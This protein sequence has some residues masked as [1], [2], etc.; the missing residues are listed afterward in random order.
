MIR[1][2]SLRVSLIHERFTELGGS[3]K[4]VDSLAAIWP[5]A[6]L[7]SPLI[8]HSVPSEALRTLGGQ[9]SSLL[10]LLYGGNGRYAHL[11]PLLPAAM[12][13]AHLPTSDVVVISHH[14]F[15]N[16]VRVAPGV[17]VVSYVHT[18]ARWLWD[19]KMRAMDGSSAPHRALLTAFA[20]TQRRRDR[21][22]AQRPDVL[23]ANS[24]AVARRIER[25]WG[26]NSI[27]VHPPVAVDRFRLDSH[28][29]REPFF[30]LAGRLVPYKRPDIAIRAARKAGVPL[31]V[32]GDGR[33]RAKCEELAGPNVTFL[34]AVSDEKLEELYRRCRALVFTGVEDF[35]IVPVEAQACGAPVVGLDQGGLRDTV[36][37][38][39]TGVLVP[40]SED[41]ARLVDGFATAMAGI[42][43]SDFDPETIRAHAETFSEQR[44]QGAM[45]SI[46]ERAATVDPDQRAASGR[47][48]NGPAGPR[49]SVADLRSYRRSGPTIL[50]DVADGS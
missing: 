32:A 2:L 8:D 20:A 10:Q 21:Q 9:E 12:A 14:A 22:A 25:W 4:V 30:L 40:P 24:S 36:L 47:G 41:E 13:R 31:V 3:E 38:G 18:P 45:K 35:G 16:R 34:G 48:G 6:H 50:S 46:V 28:V 33:A 27:V 49:G 29:T 7:F 23:V 15:A 39:R 19:A 5:H 43:C 42:R 17:P 26:R 1:D 11:L 37:A 44:F